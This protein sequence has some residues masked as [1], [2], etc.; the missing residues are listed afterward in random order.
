MGSFQRPGGVIAADQVQ[1]HEHLHIHRAHDFD[2]D[3]E[4]QGPDD[5]KESSSKSV[6]STNWSS[7]TS[8]SASSFCAEEAQQQEEGNAASLEIEFELMSD[9]MEFV[10]QAV[11]GKSSV[12]EACRDYWL[13]GINF[14]LPDML[15]FAILVSK[16]KLERCGTFYG[17]QY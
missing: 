1:P 16:K 5:G 8:S 11:L 7:S 10:E 4:S 2:L 17:W 6:S 3:D 14:L 12:H 13:G 15:Q 9:F